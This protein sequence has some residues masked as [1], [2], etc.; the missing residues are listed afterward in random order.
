M[1]RFNVARLKRDREEEEGRTIPWKEVGETTGISAS[2]LSNLASPKLGFV[3]NTR[4]VEA[5]CR[6]FRCDP[7]DLIE[8]VPTLDAEPDCNVDHLY[9]P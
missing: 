1:L 2:V 5:L 4:Y 9:P 3:T 7:G 8:L 6:Y